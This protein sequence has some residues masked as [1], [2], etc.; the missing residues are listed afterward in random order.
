MDISTFQVGGAVIH[1]VPR[2]DQ[3]QELVLTDAPV[4]LDNQLRAYLRR[5]IVESL[6][7]RGLEVVADLEG[8]PNVRNGVAE[9]IADE[10]Q[11]V[12]ASKQ[13]AIHLDNSQ[14]RRNTAGLL[15]I[16][17][18]T[19]DQAPA[20]AVLKLEREEGLRLRIESQDGQTLVDLQFL[21]DLTLTDKTKI[22][23]TSLLQLE[24]AG[25][26]ESLF[27]RVSDDQRGRDDGMGVATFFL[28]TFLG[29]KLKTNPAKATADFVAAAEVFVN[30]DVAG[31]E[32][33]GRY[34]VALQAALQDQQLDLAPQQFA[35]SQLEPQDRPAFLARV[36]EKGLDPGVA[37]TK[38]TSLVKTKGF[39]LTFTHGMVLLGSQQ[40]LRERVELPAEGQI[41]EPVILR[42]SVLALRGR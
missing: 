36:S 19:V 2:R 16:L 12:V 26:A 37:F 23:K 30:D 6:E 24:Q 3:G 1:E 22:F 20:V 41:A 33:K 29:C 21:R 42:D 8:S 39:R 4:P 27:G 38:D 9:I 40:D 11:L 13:M 14:N 5:K 10:A 7:Q 35:H 34:L 31:D 17:T 18:G 15:I 25:V 32:R 28:S